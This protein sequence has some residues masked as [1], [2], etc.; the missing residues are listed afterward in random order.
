MYECLNFEIWSYLRKQFPLSDV[1]KYRFI[2]AE[3]LKSERQCEQNRL[4]VILVTI[5][6]DDS[7][8]IVLAILFIALISR[9]PAGRYVYPRT[10]TMTHEYVH[11]YIHKFMTR[12]SKSRRESFHPVY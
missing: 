4:V 5:L 10:G 1:A 7:T 3:F 8:N 2:L 6:L 12:V 11:T 9:L